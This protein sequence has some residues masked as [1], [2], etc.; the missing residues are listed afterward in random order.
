MRV[1]Q[2]RPN[3]ML[4]PHNPAR[5]D[6]AATS[7]D[8]R[9]FAPRLPQVLDRD[10][11]R[12]SADELRPLTRI[13]GWVTARHVAL[14]WLCI[15]GTAWL[16]ERFF[17]PLLLAASCVVIGS[18]LHALG[19][20]AHDGAHGLLAKSRR[21]NDLVVELLLAWPVLL[22][23]D[24][25]RAMHQLHHR[26]LNTARDPDWAR[27]RPDRL[28]SRRG[29]VDFLRV[30][31]G[32]H[33]EQ[34]QMMN[35]VAAAANPS[36]RATSRKRLRIAIYV[37]VVALAVAARRPDLLLL[38]WLLPFATWFVFSMR[39][40]G[41]AEHF[42]V[43]NQE[44]C[45]AARTVLPSLPARLLLA[46]KNVHFHIEHHLYP[47]VPFYRLP[48]LHAALMAKP[49]FAARA[50]LTPSYWRFLIEAWRFRRA[51][52][53]DPQPAGARSP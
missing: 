35:M 33:K 25:Y 11:Y 19:I 50:H 41:T 15:L 45:N 43:E 36:P 21:R 28:E 6:G 17:S 31:G 52:A 42:A 51:G 9:D 30:L 23:F 49:G 34:R 46:P 22:S 26:E 12:L 5:V 39:W 48:A 16:C 10:D 8:D 29:V 44:A 40:K 3:R 53:A 7:D 20:L 24:G 14:E 2:D 13:D 38:Y 47:S 1:W 32:L 27:N 37:V 18:R 4:A